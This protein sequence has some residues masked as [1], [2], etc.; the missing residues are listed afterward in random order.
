MMKSRKGTVTVLICLFFA[1]LMS[2]ISAYIGAAKATALSSAVKSLGSLWGESVMAEYDLNLY[3]RYGLFGFYG[4]PAD[5]TD[6]LDFYAIRS[7]GQ[8]RYVDYEGSSARLYDYSLVN[9]AVFKKQVVKAG[10]YS[11]TDEACRPEE[12]KRIPG[13]QVTNSGTVL[14]DSLPSGGMGSS[15]DISQAIDVLRS[16]SDFR[17]LIHNT[18]DVYFENRYIDYYFKSQVRNDEL[19]ETYFD[20]EKEYIICGHKDDETNVRAIKLRIIGVRE[21]LN[22][23]FIMKTPSMCAQALAAAEVITP[24]PAAAATQKALIA[25]WALAESNNDYRLLMRG[26][27]VP[28]M[29]TEATWAI[30]LESIVNNT[31]KDVVYTGVDKGENYDDYLLLF[32]YLMDERVK[33]LRVMDL[34]QINSRYLY[35]DSF[36]LKNYNAGLEYQLNVNGKKYDFNMEY[37]KG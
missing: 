29:K 16:V 36:L 22:T 7:I 26:H 32:L 14:F 24:G 31:E 6:R 20:N 15:S 3:N 17:D 21:A 2:L 30:D 28:I 27:R 23:A 37:E 18:S 1:T 33:L 8:K 4:Q 12:I 25:A 19:G 35:Y 9:F 11:L 10:K 34:I 13:S 5:V